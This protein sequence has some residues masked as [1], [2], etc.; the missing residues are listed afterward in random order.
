MT[1]EG[2][3]KTDS[4]GQRFPRLAVVRLGG[5]ASLREPRGKSGSFGILGLIRP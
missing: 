4:T 5:D 3:K 2:L 1:R